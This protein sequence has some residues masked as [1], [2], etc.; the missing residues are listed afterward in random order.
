MQTYDPSVNYD[1]DSDDLNNSKV[2]SSKV[3]SCVQTQVGSE[4]CKATFLCM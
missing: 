1:S 4:Y 3:N 2:N